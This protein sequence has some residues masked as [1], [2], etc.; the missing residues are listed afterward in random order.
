MYPCTI[1][2]LVTDA[3]ILYV[4]IRLSQ[5]RY[6]TD[7]CCHTALSCNTSLQVEWFHMDW[8]YKQV[9]YMP[10]I[11]TASHGYMLLQANCS[12]SL[13]I[14]GVPSIWALLT[15]GV[16]STWAECYQS[17]T[18]KSTGTATVSHEQLQWH[19]TNEHEH[20]E[21]FQDTVLS[22]ASTL[23]TDS[24]VPIHSCCILPITAVAQCTGATP[25]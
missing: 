2:T 17:F 22:R 9:I 5:L 7:Y 4:A 21:H 13:L 24:T 23:H 11:C 25:L 15:S 20:D 14:F 19:F 10:L 6:A 1:H 16:L 3:H 12:R 8:F 18:A